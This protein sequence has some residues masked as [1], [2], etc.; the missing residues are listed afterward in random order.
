MSKLVIDDTWL[1]RV[2][3]QQ[4]VI[5]AIVIR[6][7]AR[8]SS[9]TTTRDLQPYGARRAVQVHLN[10]LVAAEIL[11]KSRGIVTEYL[12]HPSQSEFV[13]SVEMNYLF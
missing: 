13:Q 12:P 8:T 11:T 7:Y 9:Y 3:Y 4:A 10:A 6:N 1:K 2:S 5:A